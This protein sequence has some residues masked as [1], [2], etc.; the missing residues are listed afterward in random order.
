MPNVTLQGLPAGNADL[1]YTARV[2]PYRQGLVPRPAPLQTLAV[3]ADGSVTFNLTTGLSYCV[4]GSDG[5][6]RL[7]MSATTKG[8]PSP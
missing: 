5:K 1:H 2:E 3:A 7:C 4:F 6:G 8:W